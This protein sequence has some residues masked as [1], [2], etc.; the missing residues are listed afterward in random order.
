[1][2]SL[3]LDKRVGFARQGRDRGGD[4]AQRRVEVTARYRWRGMT[5]ERLGD[6][7]AG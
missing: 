1:M 2:A 3:I 6:R 5:S 4:L 7:V